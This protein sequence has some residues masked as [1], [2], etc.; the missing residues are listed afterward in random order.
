[1]ILCK[2]LVYACAKP[3]KCSKRSCT[4]YILWKI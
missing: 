4:I 3:G 2:K 1:M